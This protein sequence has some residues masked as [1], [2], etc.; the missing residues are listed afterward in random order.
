MGDRCLIKEAFG[1]GIGIGNVD[2]FLLFVDAVFC[3][4]IRELLCALH[5]VD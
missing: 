5:S 2:S 4:W 1:G 3:L